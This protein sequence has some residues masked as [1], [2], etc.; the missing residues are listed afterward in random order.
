MDLSKA[1][2][3]EKK[4]MLLDFQERFN[5]SLTKIYEATM[6]D[7]NWIGSD[8][9]GFFKKQV[10]TY[11]IREDA[12]LV[13]APHDPYGWPGQVSILSCFHFENRSTSSVVIPSVAAI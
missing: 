4:Q 8:I 1:Q 2:P 7:K 5:T 3:A 6:Q 11:C 9:W 12:F 10:D 13:S